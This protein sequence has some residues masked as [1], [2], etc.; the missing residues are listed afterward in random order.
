M[1][2]RRTIQH[3]IPD[4]YDRLDRIT[5][6]RKRHDYT[7][8]EILLGALFMFICKQDSRNAA[9]NDGANSTF[10]AN[11]ETLFGKRL[12]H[13]DTVDEVLRAVDNDE[14]EYLKSALIALLIEK[15][16]FGKFRLLDTF[17][18]V[19]VDATGVMNVSEGHCPHCLHKTSKNGI[20]TYFHN[21]LE[22]KLITPNGFA[23][24]LASEW[25]E[26]PNEYDKQD[27]ELKAFKRLAMKLKAFY[28]R[29][30]I[31][32]LGD[33]LYPNAPFF[34]ICKTNNWRF[35]VTLKDASLKSLWEEIDL[36]LLTNSKNIK[37]SSQPQRNISQTYRWL[38]GLTYQ[39][40][41]LSW[42]EC[43]EERDSKVNRFV[44]L[45]D[46]E[47]SFDNVMELVTSGRMRFKIENEG[48]N[49]LK[50]GGYNLSHKFSRVSSVAMK[51]Y[52]SLMQIA[53][54]INQ[55]YELSTLT[56]K[57]LIG[58]ETL[59]SIWKAFIGCITHT[60]LVEADVIAACA[61]RFQIRY[62]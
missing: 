53:H 37:F 20:V 34:D 48:F 29:L 13:M 21:I 59:K 55:L 39:E 2:L 1:D 22:A 50:N 23:M 32:I 44:Y 57:L 11:Y 41:N 49:T 40:H 9:N 15:K 58:K 35:V 16:V 17:Y 8:T 26:N 46:I 56:K 25:I 28:P 5:D 33:G 62:E 45:T 36:E 4:L 3:F 14:I 38:A 27:C 24:S 43:V 10:V 31:C 42:V 60:V 7:M 51:N 18:R 30:P 61:G 6:H 12:P 19:A 52:V 47:S 54:L